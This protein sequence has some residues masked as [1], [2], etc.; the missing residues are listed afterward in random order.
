[1]E[2]HDPD[3]LLHLAYPL[4]WIWV[5]A[6]WCDFLCHRVTGL[7]TTSGLAESRLHLLQ[8]ASMGVAIILLLSLEPTAGL[9]LV[10]LVLV[11]AHAIAGYLD[12]RVAFTAGRTILP[13]EQHLHSVLDI[14]PWL[15]W[16]AVTWRVATLPS[17][18]W[19]LIARDDA[20]PWPT[21]AMVLGPALVLCGLPALT[22]FAAAARAAQ[23]RRD[24]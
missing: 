12:T 22:E 16:G 24:A 18:D 9:A 17:T 5:I 8:L 15:G 13:V 3:L 2:A 7:P 23:G 21:W 10:L 11:V 20:L 1:M 6:G 4:Y 14:A 19:A